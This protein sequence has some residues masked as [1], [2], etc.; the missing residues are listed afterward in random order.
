M[1]RMDKRVALA[2]RKMSPSETYSNA[3]FMA[4]KRKLG[5]DAAK[6]CA[7][8][9]DSRRGPH[10]PHGTPPE[11]MRKDP[12]LIQAFWGTSYGP[13]MLPQ[14][15]WIAEQLAVHLPDDRSACFTVDVGG[16]IGVVAAAV[17]NALGCRG[18]SVDPAS[19]TAQLAECLADLAG[20]HVE[21]HEEGAEN[22]VEIFARRRPSALYTMGS[23][24]YMQLPAHTNERLN[25]GRDPGAHPRTLRHR[26]PRS[27]GRSVQR[28]IAAAS[29]RAVGIATTGRRL[30]ADG[31]GVGEARRVSRPSGSDTA[32]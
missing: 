7:K 25:P 12:Y 15:V 28:A 4:A 13:L 20:A 17:S 24:Y 5:D 2:W 14:A 22:L 1:P 19:H 23:L 30:G 11:W 16:G 18:V 26:H 32:Y 10:V 31:S 21:V 8:R 9:L 29:P 27:G 3:V 6:A